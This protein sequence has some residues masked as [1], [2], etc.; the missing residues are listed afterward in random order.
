[1][2]QTPKSI[3]VNVLGQTNATIYTV[4][5]L[6]T[7]VV[8][9]VIG[10]NADTSGS[11]LTVSKYVSGQNFP[12]TANQ[13]PIYSN[14]TGATSVFGYNLIS[15]PITMA[16]G[17]ELKVYPNA[18]SYYNLPNV[19]TFTNASDGNAP[20]IN[21]VYYGNG[22]YVA[23]GYTSS[24]GAFI[25]TSTDA[26]TWT[27]NTA[28]IPLTSA[29]DQVVNV[30]STWLA[31]NN[32][33]SASM[34]YSTD[35]GVT[36][37]PSAF[38]VATPL[39]SLAASNST[40]VV[41]GNNGRIYYS[42]DGNT[43]TES[44]SFITATGSAITVYAVSWSG[45]HFMVSNAF[46]TLATTDLV[47]W[48]SYASTNFGRN[49]SGVWQSSTWSSA[50]SRYYT[51]R[52]NSSTPNI[53]SSPNGLLWTNLLSSTVYGI[54]K[55]AAA[56][57]NTVILGMPPT[58]TSDRLVST[59][60]TT[61]TAASDV[62]GLSGPVFGL[63][64]GYFLSCGNNDSTMSL[65]TNPTTISG[66]TRSSLRAGY[67]TCA[68][69]DPVSGQWVAFQTADGSNT[70]FID[71][72][73]SGTNIAGTSYN[74]TLSAASVGAAQSVCWSAA[75]SYFYMITTT[76]R[77]Y[78]L[79]TYNTGFTSMGTVP[80]GGASSSG[81]QCDIMAVGT[82]LYAITS[83]TGVAATLYIGST[84]TGGASWVA[85]DFNG[86]SYTNSYLECTTATRDGNYW[87]EALS[88]NG[89]DILWVNSRGWCYV[90]TPSVAATSMRMPVIPSG[91]VQTVNSINFVY[92]GYWNSGGYPLYGYFFSNNAMTTYGTWVALGNF[93]AYFNS[94]QSP[95]NKFAYVGSN[96]YGME[97]GSNY[98]YSNSTPT[99]STSR[100]SGSTI[101]GVRVVMP[102]AGFANDGTNL[103]GSPK[104]SALYVCKTTTP[105]NFLY[106]ATM[107]AS[108]I[109]ID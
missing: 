107:T 34:L 108:I 38:G 32:S 98:L 44:T 72:G 74:T 70:I 53:N 16:A 65:S 27:Q 64:N 106:A 2:A 41:G 49:A 75:D 68:A 10:T 14:A 80:S 89:T 95:A 3:S 7:A 12:I 59:N 46:G 1:M 69:A 35:N 96:Y 85:Q 104:G 30:G 37:A 76:G 105:S 20:V 42:T 100:G 90:I 82:T 87:G 93:S 71:G 51:C 13:A 5:A 15:S 4:P 54:Q 86:G 78:R 66:T 83:N 58:G 28:V 57:S 52:N 63:A 101:A 73:T 43:W 11:T 6:K 8:K 25:A 92:G 94:N 23:V 17:E 39:R 79:T 60:G 56:G 99:M 88:T 47:T 24:G 55:M 29:L 62:N 102:I 61:F 9:T 67:I 77:V 21:Q 81:H 109:E 45:S 48:F 91:Y 19:S 36:W 31:T 103:A 50:Y 22:K 26:V 84:L 97:M 18:A 40:F 33:A